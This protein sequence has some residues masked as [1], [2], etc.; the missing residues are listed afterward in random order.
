[1]PTLRIDGRLVE[2]P[3]G[4]TILDAARRLGI[5]IPTLCWREGFACS[6]SCMVCAVKV[7]GRERLLP[8]CGT[9]AEQG[10]DV[11]TDDDEV[12]RFRR[13]VL[14]LL[15]SDH[16][17]DCEGP[18]SLAC[19]AHLDIPALVRAVGRGDDAAAGDLARAALA[20][21]ETLGL[22]CPAPC[23]KACRRGHADAPVAVRALHRFAARRRRRPADMPPPA[24]AAAG[25]TPG[26]TII[27][28]GPA[29]LAAAAELTRRGHA[30]IVLDEHPEPGGMLRYGLEP[31]AARAEALAADTAAIAALGVEFRLGVR[32]SSPE[33]LAR[34]RAQ[35]AAVLVATGE[36]PGAAALGL[37]MGPAGVLADRHTG[38]TSVDGVFAAGGAVRETRRM[39]V[40]A[41]AAGRAAAD[42]IDRWL[43]GAPAPPH[44]YLNV[45]MGRLREGELERFLALAGPGAR[46]VDPG[47]AP[48]PE[49]A[50]R[51]EAGRCLHC[52][53]RAAGSCA[54]RTLAAEYGAAP[55]R[56][57][58]TRRTFEYDATH[59]DVIYEPGKCIAC[60][61]CVQAAARAGERLGTTFLWRGIAVRVGP[62]LGE[63]MAAALGAGAADCVAVCPTGALAWK[64]D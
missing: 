15:L 59:P 1:M 52:D 3:G 35:S 36:G 46:A 6:T 34:W 51:A 19:P 29:G 40:R 60:G 38:V 7:A 55:H 45:S 17:G 18:C 27:G 25:R 22:V 56:W 16:T 54:L 53:C 62:P 12:R 28:A 47:A 20:L 64:R 42:Q 23:E 32:V 2:V 63:T 58:G 8:A 5:P 39:A 50:A 37:A 9:P 10:M 48:L 24:A 43:R 61:L 33:D 31:D 13:E 21:P 26:V 30:C 11:T 41:V 14:E 4:A 57:A 44:R 49:P